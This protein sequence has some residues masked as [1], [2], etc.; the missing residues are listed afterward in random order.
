MTR[1]RFRLGVGGVVRD[2]QEE[3]DSQEHTHD[4]NWAE[5][6]CVLDNNNNT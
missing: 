3:E 2:V 1:L 4:D 5:E 6:R